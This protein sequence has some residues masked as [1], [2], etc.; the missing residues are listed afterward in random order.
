MPQEE[1]QG[2]VWHSSHTI[3][4]K[5]QFENLC[6]ETYKGNQEPSVL[7]NVTNQ[8]NLTV[9]LDNNVQLVPLNVDN[10]DNDILLKI[11]EDTHQFFKTNQKSDK[12]C[13]GYSRHYDEHH[14]HCDKYV[15]PTS[16]FW[17]PSKNVFPKH[18]SN[19]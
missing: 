7:N 17:F 9:T 15:K 11:L 1:N 18:H 3:K 10:N 16:I 12:Q 6:V 14:K 19:H 13:T 2:N 5:I 4:Q 8:N